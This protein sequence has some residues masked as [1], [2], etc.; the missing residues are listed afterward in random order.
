MHIF[1]WI[2]IQTYIWVWSRIKLCLNFMILTFY[3]TLILIFFILHLAEFQ[4][5]IQFS[6]KET[7]HNILKRYIWA[8]L[9][10]GESDLCFVWI[11]FRILGF[12]YEKYDSYSQL[13]LCAIISLNV[14]VLLLNKLIICY[15]A[16]FQTSMVVLVLHYLLIMFPFLWQVKRCFLMISL[17]WRLSKPIILHPSG[18]Y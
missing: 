9:N 10:I 5:S 2:L 11:Y 18:W 13:G 15:L 6:F 7:L 1:L 3:K 17:Y 14:K 8:K 4:D 16:K 12:C